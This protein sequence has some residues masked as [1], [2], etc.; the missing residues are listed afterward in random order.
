[1]KIA[2]FGGAFNP[3]H[4]EHI[5]IAKAA[6]KE[7]KLDRLIVM[8]SAISPHKSG[9]LIADGQDRLEMC[10]LAFAEVDG[11]VVSDYEVAKGDVSY[12]YLTCAYFKEKYPDAEL[13][14]LIG[15]DMLDNFPKW[16]NPREILSCVTLAAC[17][18]ENKEEYKKYKKTVENEFGTHVKKVSYIGDSVNSTH[19][20]TLAAL[21]ED[22]EVYVTPVVCQYI[23]KR[24]L[25]VLKNIRKIK[26]FLKPKR[27]LHTVRVAE[28]CAKYKESASLSEEQ[29]I[30]M[31]ALHDVAKYLTCDSPYLNGFVLPEGVPEPVIH[32]FAGAYVAEKYFGVKD[33]IILDAIR[34]HTSA[35]PCMTKADTLLYLCD[36][37]EEGR[38]FEGVDMLR[39]LF[40]EDMDRC[41]Y[42]A[43][44]Q[45]VEYLHS[46][47]KPVYELTE[48]AYEYLA[49]KNTKGNK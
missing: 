3:V 29:A 46:T 49:L 42:V 6:I 35:R 1:M 9:D 43:L 37:L 15:A 26:E 18:R 22:I 36:M 33:E 21:G 2:I 48:K 11:A 20:R 5:N 24:Q 47:G 30:T 7:L 34:Y 28:M 16:K 45:Q 38:N 39:K 4:C 17:A 41:L 40:K 27:W 32:Q 44:K 19:I 23:N 31:G 8:P 14:W 10:R 13:Y 25:Y 12:S